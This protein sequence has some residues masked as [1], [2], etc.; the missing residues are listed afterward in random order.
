MV[1]HREPKKQ[2]K[3]YGHKRRNRGKRRDKR[4][5]NKY[6]NQIERRQ[7]LYI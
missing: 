2:G 7:N 1:R 3:A 4:Q 6:I 5:I